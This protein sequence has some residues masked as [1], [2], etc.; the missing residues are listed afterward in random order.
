VATTGNVVNHQFY[1]ISFDATFAEAPRFLADMQTTNGGDAAAVRWGNRDQYGIEVKVEEDKSRD[2]ETDHCTEVVGYMAFSLTGPGAPPV[3]D[4]SATH[5]CGSAPLSVDFTDLSAGT[6]YS[7]S[8]DFDNDGIE[9]SR[10]QNPTYTFSEPGTYTVKLEVFGPYGS[11]D[12][13]KVDLI[14]VNVTGA[15]LNMEVGELIDLTHNWKQVGFSRC[16]LDPVVVAKPLSY[17]GSDPSLVRLRNVDIRGFEIRLQEWDYLD[18]GHI[19][20]TVSYVVMERGSHV[21]A[22][23]TQVEA[24]SFMT[25]LTSSFGTFSFNQS[26]QAVPVVVVAVASFNEAAAVTDRLRNIST[27]GFEFRMQEQGANVQSHSVETIHYIAWEPGS[28]TVNEL[29]FEVATTGDGVTDQFYP[30]PFNST[31]QQAPM[32]LADMQTTHGEDTAA[33][34]WQNRDAYKVEVKIEE[35]QSFDAEMVHITEVVGYMAFS[36]T[37]PG[38][39]PVADFSATYICGA[40]PLRVDFTDLSNGTIDSWSWDFDNDGILDSA[41]QHPTYTYSEPGTYTVKL[42]VSGPYG[43]DNETKVDFINVNVPGTDPNIVEIGEVSVLDH[44]WKQVILSRCF[45]DPVV[46]AKP[47]SYNGSDPALV[48]LRNVDSRGFEI[49]LQEWDYLDGAHTFGETVSYVVMERGSHILDDGTQVEA[50]SFM[51]NLTSSFGTFSFNQSFQVVPVVVAAV[52]SFSEADAVTDRLRNIT[53]G[54][55]DFRMQEQGANVQSHSVET[56]HYIAWEPG[57]GTANGLN[58]EVATTGNAVTDQF[59]PISFSST[60]AEGPRFLADMQSTHGEDTAAMRWRNRNPQGVEVK[61]EEDQ[62]FDE[63]TVHIT[64]VVGYMAFSA[65]S[66]Q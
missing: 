12:E 47:L 25:N 7:W 40:E 60:F 10:D 31:F 62:S 3:A 20:E 32:F 8:W 38:A 36:L 59:S 16:F 49:R 22:D 64:E 14:N 13:I 34:R 45:V 24:G 42:T 66:I 1:P 46:V 19:S 6:I 58:F 55:F 27:E 51:T 57:L 15:D 26:F 17:N 4:F 41:D 18:G 43:S 39:P 56:I 48:R 30:I 28:G 33:V 54:G 21:L 5:S 44:N 52:A 23:G 2:S 37:G 61:I 53:T 29:S 11:D 65:S 50:G 9:D 63:E 35:D